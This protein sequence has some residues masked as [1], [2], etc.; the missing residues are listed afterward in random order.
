MDIKAINSS[1]F[2]KYVHCFFSI[3][4]FISINILSFI[5]PQSHSIMSY[6]IR[7]DNKLDLDNNWISRKQS[8]IDIF[9]KYQPSVI[10]IQE[11]LI[12]QVHFIDSSLSNYDYVGVGRDDG[13]N[14]GE[15]CAIYYNRN[16]LVLIR[17]STFWLSKT[18][19]K[20]SVGWDAALE[21]ICTY[22]LLKD[23]KT[24][25][26]FY[27][28]NTHYD[29]VGK[30][31]RERS[32]R[33]IMDKIFE[34]NSKELPVVLIGDFNANPDSPEIK[35]I[36]DNFSDALNI[37]K[38][39]LIGPT[40]TF[41]GFDLESPIDKRIDYIFTKG[42]DIVSYMHIDQ[43]INNKRHISDHLPVIIKMR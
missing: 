37:S 7:Y 18:P 22:A 30:K 38:S 40:G 34:I 29:H 41:N 12:N 4:I 23:I 6:N 14:K 25:N 42:I 35:I 3:T 31:A 9:V 20:V 15:F 8:I 43:K 32:S 11:G 19:Y 33:L 24:Q 39:E 28:F 26:E 36:K 2:V 27:V 16:Q 17:N 21:R 5:Y 13:K 1:K 10:G